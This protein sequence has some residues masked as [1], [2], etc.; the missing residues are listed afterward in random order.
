MAAE[1]RIGIGAGGMTL[2]QDLALEAVALHRVGAGIIQIGVA[3]ENLPVPE[4]NHAAALAR[5]PVEQVDVDRIQPVL[6]LLP[7]AT[8]PGR[9]APAALCQAGGASSTRRVGR[10][11]RSA[12]IGFEIPSQDT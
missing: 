8:V 4:K 12:G 11:C 6:H 1:Q 9:G 5:T 7:D 10:W 2:D 3:A